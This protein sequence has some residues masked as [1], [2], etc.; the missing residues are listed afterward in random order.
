MTCELFVVPLNEGTE[1]P[2][3]K[4]AS[5]VLQASELHELSVL[6]GRRRNQYLLSRFYLKVIL[7]GLYGV[8][9]PS[10]MSLLRQDGLPPLL[11][12]PADLY[13]SISH[14]RDVVL[15]AVSRSASIAVDVEW[16]RG[17]DFLEFSNTYFHPRVFTEINVLDGNDLEAV[18]YQYWV[19]LEAGLKLAKGSVFSDFMSRCCPQNVLED[20]EGPL[21]NS[22]AGQYREYSIALASEANMIPRLYLLD[23][24][25]RCFNFLPL[26]VDLSKKVFLVEA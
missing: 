3:E 7:S 8:A 20:P 18:F 14:S 26:D 21:F 22:Y 12:P 25:E 2:A 15:L 10:R 6:K 24:S 1:R 5:L 17:R 4:L 23:C 13:F 16:H 9:E 19:R 11:D